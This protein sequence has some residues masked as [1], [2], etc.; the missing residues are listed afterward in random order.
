ML[1]A[2]SVTSGTVSA[3]W[4]PSV[5]SVSDIGGAR[6][7]YTARVS[8][9]PA[10]GTSSTA[11]NA[12]SPTLGFETNTNIPPENDA[13]FNAQV[14]SGQAPTVAGESQATNQPP[15]LGTGGAGAETD[16]PANTTVGPA[17]GSGVTLSQPVEST[18]ELAATNREA[19]A[20]E[21]R[22]EQVQEDLD[23]IITGNGAV[24]E[25]EEELLSVSNEPDLPPAGMN[26]LVMAMLL[27]FDFSSQTNE[28]V[29]SNAPLPAAPPVEGLNISAGGAAGF[30]S[31]GLA[32]DFDADSQTF[33]LSGGNRTL[34]AA[35]P[36]DE[37]GQVGFS[38]G[39]V[40]EI[41]GSFDP[42]TSLSDVR[43][44]VSQGPGVASFGG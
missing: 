37:N 27:G 34:S 10:S 3:P 31:D 39:V 30:S 40:L 36:E 17:P 16:I 38:N 6:S 43:V 18:L 25:S 13:R 33:T 32:L 1:N 41:T 20:R 11:A 42:T 4:V 24:E 21:A 35:M 19:R 2:A 5:S 15:T 23:R 26:P 8:S 44:S 7:A 28:V 12:A 22:E 29:V 14:I 9:V